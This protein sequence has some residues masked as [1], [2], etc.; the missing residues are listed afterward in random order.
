MRKTI[1]MS[2]VHVDSQL[3]ND[4]VDILSNSMEITP[5]M[6][7]FWQEQEKLFQR[8]STGVKFH[9]MVIRYCLSLASKSQSCYEELRN[10]N[11]LVLPSLRTLRDYKNCIRPTTGFNEDI[12]NDLT[13]ITDKYF[14]T[15]RYITLLFDEMTL[16]SNLV[17]DRNTSELIGFTD[18]GDPDLNFAT[19]DNCDD[20]AT[21][22]LVFM[23]RGICTKLKYCMSYFATVNVTSY[24]LFSLF[25]EAVFILELKCNLWVVAVTADGA[26]ANRAMFRMHYLLGEDYSDKT[27]TYRTINLYAK[28]RF[29][30]FI[31]DAPHL[32]KTLRNYLFHSGF[33]KS[34]RHMWKNGKHLYW[35]HIRNM[36]NN[37]QERGLKLLPR[38]T[39]EH[40]YLKSFSLMTV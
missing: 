16:K 3:C 33:G 11:I 2:S 4:S 5:F 15:E 6:N 35:E 20:L 37:D 21:H 38:L 25:W 27:L 13:N 12:I 36:Y 29:I 7:L 28:Y 40:I 39:Q 10:S 30:Y 8:S 32:V 14:N 31:S 34:S 26:S 23:A 19:L 17:F 18:L 24:Q 1:E 9:P 22:T